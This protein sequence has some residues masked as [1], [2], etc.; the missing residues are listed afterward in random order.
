MRKKK[1]YLRNKKKMTAQI[2]NARLKRVYGISQEDYNEMLKFQ[3]ARCAI[4]GRP[5]SRG[6]WKGLH[7]D[8][9]HAT[10]KIRGLLC[11]TCNSGLG[12]FADNPVL[13]A[14]ASAYL[15]REN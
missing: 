12:S 4:C 8:H 5:D 1:Y 11:Y 7:I 10:N 9:D 15:K 13:L 3:N 14:S 2:R 6:R